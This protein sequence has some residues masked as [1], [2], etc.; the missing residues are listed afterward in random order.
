M[1][2]DEPAVT[3]LVPLKY[4]RSASAHR[5]R[6]CRPGAFATSSPSAV[7]NCYGQTEI[8]GEIVGWNAADSGRTATRSSARSVA[9]T[10]GVELRIADTGELQVR[11]PAVTAGY[12]DG[13]QLADRLTADGW[14]PY[15]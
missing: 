2:C 6:R 13:G 9:R 4:V 7:L 1:L 8:G 10:K 12:A 14:F 5:S 3:S 15:R 11:T